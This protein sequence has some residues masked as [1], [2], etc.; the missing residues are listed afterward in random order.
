MKTLI[1]ERY[2][3]GSILTAEGV[4]NWGFAENEIDGI[5]V[6]ENTG[7][8]YRVIGVKRD[9]NDTIMIITEA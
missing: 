8:V 9:E 1:A 2:E 4:F 3:K 5:L 6:S 7:E